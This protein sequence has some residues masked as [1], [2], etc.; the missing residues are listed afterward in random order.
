M[1][2]LSLLS[3]LKLAFKYFM[4]KSNNIFKQSIFYK[5]NN[6]SCINVTQYFSFI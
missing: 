1:N 2:Q 3:K 4:F 6:V 5:S